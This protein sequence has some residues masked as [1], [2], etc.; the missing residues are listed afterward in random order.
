[1]YCVAAILQMAYLTVIGLYFSLETVIF[2]IR[3]RVSPYSTH[4]VRLD[5]FTGFVSEMESR[6]LGKKRNLSSSAGILVQWLTFSLP[7]MTEISVVIR[8]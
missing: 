7:Y 3:M 6:L 8:Q 2:P 5:F 4:D 1:M